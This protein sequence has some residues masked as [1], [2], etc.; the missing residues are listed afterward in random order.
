MIRLEPN[1][2]LLHYFKGFILEKLENHV[3]AEEAYAL[4][5][6]NMIGHLGTRLSI[7]KAIK[8]IAENT[9]AEFIDLKQIFDNWEHARGS[10]YN[11][12]LII[13]DCHPSPAGQRLIAETLYKVIMKK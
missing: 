13:D 9:N 5:R 2:A 6:E 7:N 1:V 10:Y 4:A 11:H 12:H 8:D 3:K